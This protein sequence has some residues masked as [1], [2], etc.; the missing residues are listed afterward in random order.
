MKNLIEFSGKDN[1]RLEVLV[2][3][4]RTGRLMPGLKPQ[5]SLVAADGSVYDP[6]ELPLTG[7]SWLNHYG[8]NLRI[9]RKGLYKLRVS[10][11]AP[12]FRRWGR[13]SGRFASPVEVEF[14]NLS[15]KPEGK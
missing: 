9:P 6:G 2:R 8:R 10:F 7:H 15:L 11:D 1:V 14:D 4:S 5:A 12:G 13:Q 3:D